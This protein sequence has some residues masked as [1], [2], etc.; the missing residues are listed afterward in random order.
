MAGRLG[1]FL[2]LA[3]MGLRNLWPRTP[4]LSGADRLSDR[5]RLDIGI[6][7]GSIAAEL[8]REMAKLHTKHLR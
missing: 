5:D 8:G 4:R 2:R 3:G 7:Q 6:G 1:G